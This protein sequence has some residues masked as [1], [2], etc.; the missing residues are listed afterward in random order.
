MLY[1]KKAQEYILEQSKSLHTLSQDIPTNFSDVIDYILQVKGHII[2][3]GM[4]KSGYIAQKIASSFA[5]TGTPAFFI[6]PA[7]AG[8]G[9]LGMI[10]AQDMVIIIS[11]SGATE[12]LLHI[13]NYCKKYNIRTA[14]ITMKG[15]SN[16]M[17]NVDYILTIPNQKEISSVN[18][19]TTS[20]LM[21]L[22]LGDAIVTVIHE[23][24]GFSAKDFKLLHPVGKI[25]VNLLQVF[26][27][28][29]SKHDIPIVYLDYDFRDV[30]LTITEKGLGC[31]L[32]GDSQ[33]KM[34]GIITDKDLRRSIENNFSNK[35]TVSDV[36]TTQY[37]TV[38]ADILASEA[39][40]IMN[41][42]SILALPVLE[43]SRIVGIVHMQDIL[44]S[45]L[46]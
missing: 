6:H 42:Q 9:D 29:R 45:G 25:G 30:I 15:E 5:S 31:T 27:I 4:G 1:H 22:S 32:V 34:L 41:T 12:E 40:N 17:N 21:S 44:R 19:P 2:T 39:L 8:H 23:S 18:A 16:L 13:I 46:S 28:M 24:K 20:S 37:T 38:S 11:N 26:D 7:E 36:M 3:T 10:T 33:N 43:K 35:M 14:A